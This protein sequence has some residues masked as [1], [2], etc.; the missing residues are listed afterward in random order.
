MVYP[1]S[2]K[3]KD[4]VPYPIVFFSKNEG[5]YPLFFWGYGVIE[6]IKYAK[7]YVDLDYLQT[8]SFINNLVS[9]TDRGVCKLSKGKV[10]DNVISMRKI[11]KATIETYIDHEINKKYSKGIEIDVERDIVNP[12]RRFLFN[13]VVNIDRKDNWVAVENLYTR[14]I[15]YSK[16][17]S[18]KSVEVYMDKLDINRSRFKVIE[19]FMK[20]EMLFSIDRKNIEFYLETSYNNPKHLHY[21]NKDEITPNSYNIIDYTNDEYFKFKNNILEKPIV[22]E[23]I[24]EDGRNIEFY[25][26]ISKY[27]DSIAESVGGKES[28]KIKLNLAEPGISK[29]IEN[30]LKYKNVDTLT[31]IDIK[32][33]KGSEQ[34][35]FQFSDFETVKFVDSIRVPIDKSDSKKVEYKVEVDKRNNKGSE[36]DNLKTGIRKINQKSL[37]ENNS[38][39]VLVFDINTIEDKDVKEALKY[40][41]SKSIVNLTDLL[42]KD[43][44]K[45]EKRN[46]EE[47]SKS[48]SKIISRPNVEGLEKTKKSL[49]NPTI[50][51]GTKKH[52]KVN[53]VVDS[54]SKSFGGV[55]AVS[56]IDKDNKKGVTLGRRWRFRTGDAF[57]RIWLNPFLNGAGKVV[58]DRLKLLESFS[59]M[60]QLIK[61]DCFFLDPDIYIR[62]TIILD[63]LKDAFISN[64]INVVDVN[65]EFQYLIQSF[66]KYV[67]IYIDG[68]QL[69][70]VNEM[71]EVVLDNVYSEYYN[72]FIEPLED[73]GTDLTVEAKITFKAM[74]DFILFIEQLIYSN[75][76]F[77][78]ASIPEHAIN[79]IQKVLD[80]W[81]IYGKPADEVPEEYLY[82]VRWF[83]WWAEG[84]K[85]RVVN[86]NSL[87]GMQVL[88][89]IRDYMVTYFETRWGKRQV[90][91]APEDMLIDSRDESYLNRIRGKKHST[92]S[93]RTERRD[94]EAEY[95]FK[96]EELD[97][98][99]ENDRKK[100]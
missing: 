51:I 16:P 85:Q 23:I 31:V 38:R 87:T 82:L 46:K 84:E 1:F 3:F 86:D 4:V 72:V 68:D 20:D 69:V 22:E 33:L 78:A 39:E 88:Y 43:R 44:L 26:D 41:N 27:K 71:F 83:H 65:N 15:D 57:D 53:T 90:I 100:D 64:Q 79:D 37:E 61:H 56:D 35:P 32:E 30:I 9:K 99:V 75:R 67:D 60:I 25:L 8:S 80:D 70:N 5:I 49:S 81:L 6:V 29:E 11:I 45:L 13:L 14:F 95:G 62:R 97:Y 59:K 42:L 48:E 21:D 47:V 55:N 98:D 76:F 58:R 96:E 18:P 66:M 36:V 12:S 28:N 94:L 19:Y 17:V 73:L 74:L 7:K 2:F 40:V 24:K 93:R 63:S 91:Y 89:N 50:D 34:K 54:S 77:Y 52:K 10:V 92:T